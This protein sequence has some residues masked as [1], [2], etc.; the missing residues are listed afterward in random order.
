MEAEKLTAP[1]LDPGPPPVLLPGI[2]QDLRLLPG[3][4]HRDGSPS[5][6]ILDP[7]RNQFFEIGWLEF[8]LLARWKEHENAD[9]LIEDVAADTPL[10]PLVEEIQELIQF[11]ATNQLLSPGTP[12]VRSELRGRMRAQV[13]PWYE[14]LL[15]HYLFF[16]VPLLRPDAFLQRSLPLASFFFTRGFAFAVFAAFLVD[17]FLV[18]RECLTA[19]T[20]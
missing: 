13:K 4:R 16:R 2:R 17:M 9:S 5:W 1:P 11:L 20:T 18:M 19:C 6:R 3:P 8:E 10:T 12:G 14:T 15:H 7:V